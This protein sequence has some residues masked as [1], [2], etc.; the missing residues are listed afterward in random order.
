MADALVAATAVE[1]RITLCTANRK[2]C[3]LVKD[4]DLSTFRP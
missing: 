4:L 2:H 3:R 1:N